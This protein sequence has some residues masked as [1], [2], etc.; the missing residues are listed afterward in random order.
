MNIIKPTIAKML[1]IISVLTVLP[2]HATAKAPVPGPGYVTKLVGMGFGIAKACDEF[3]KK[4]GCIAQDNKSCRNTSWNM[5]LDSR[6]AVSACAKRGPDHKFVNDNW[7]NIYS[8]GC[9]EDQIRKAV[10]VANQNKCRSMPV[11]SGCKRNG[12]PS[13]NYGDNRCTSNQV[14][15]GQT[16]TRKCSASRNQWIAAN[17]KPI[18]AFS[19]IA[20]R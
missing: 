20:Y 8:C 9:T 19:G 16:S 14:A 17:I 13:F 10:R 18:P 3:Y 15:I 11:L 4:T 12:A 7:N 1:F 6:H 5:L 2:F